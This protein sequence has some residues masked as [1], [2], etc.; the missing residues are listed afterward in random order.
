[1][2]T[3]K[4]ITKLS[5]VSPV[6]ALLEATTKLL[7]VVPAKSPKP[8]LSNIRFSVEH[9]ILELA[10]TDYIAG[11]HYSIPAAKLKAEGGGLL[12]GARFA[13]YLKEYRGAEAAITFDPRGGCH[14]KA[15]GGRYKIVGDDPRDYPKLPRF[16][17]KVGFAMTGEVITGM[18][19]KT[20]F[21]I[22]PEESRMTTNGVLFE[23]KAGRFR[24]V[25]TDNKRMSIT[26]Q[27]VNT[28]ID[29]FSVSVPDSFL[30][31]VLKVTSKDVSSQTATIGVDGKRVFY[32]IGTA[33]VY[34]T[35]LQGNYPPYEE[36]LRIRLKH[37][38]DCGVSDLLSTIKRAM[39]VDRGL[40]AFN[41]ETGVLTLASSS[42]S[43]GVGAA[44]MVIDFELPEGEEK[45]RIGLNPEFIRDGLEA[46]T[47]KRCRFLF[48]GPRNAGI[49]KELVAAIGSKSV[50]EDVSDEY[51]YATM[52]ALL[53]PEN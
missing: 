35:T 23:L 49:L 53:P 14:F 52:P 20:L 34:S 41:F 38:I 25:A 15:K 24:L 50:T 43:V 47:A 44:D 26:E 13:D 39:L 51:V 31:A 12:N 28:E 37:H 5:L 46:M 18:I 30:K 36:A 4:K 21:A 10:G 48:E 33:T 45:I 16:D 7:S 29:D 22:A 9:G 27:M 3:A 2:T 32:K 6:D 11:I 19:K 42:S 1:M 8:V 40:T 17:G